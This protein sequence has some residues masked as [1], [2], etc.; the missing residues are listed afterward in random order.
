MTPNMLMFGREVS[1]PLDLMFEMPS[2]IISGFGSCKIELNQLTRRYERTLSNQCAD[3]NSCMTREH[4]SK[5]QNRRPSVCV[6]PGK[7]SGYLIEVSFIFEGAIQSL[8]YCLMSY[9][10]LTVGEMV[11]ISP[12]TAIGF[13][14]VRFKSGEV[15]A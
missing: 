13:E 8:E 1:T 4:L 2:Q 6:F 12:F 3:K 5:I 10:R 9:I 15:K 11:L 14:H 7:T